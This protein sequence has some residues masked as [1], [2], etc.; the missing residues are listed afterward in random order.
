MKINLPENYKSL[1]TI[2]DLKCAKAVIASLKSDTSTP[3]DYAQMGVNVIASK[4]NTYCNEILTASA[5]VILNYNIEWDRMCDNGGRFDVI[6]E[7]WAKL[8]FRRVI[9]FEMYLS[10]I[11]DICYDVQETL[12]TLYNHSYVVEYK[13]V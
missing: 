13:K 11:W 7:G 5:R 12:D 6:I 10:E 8:D 4:M 2:N 9:H 1:Y 3:T